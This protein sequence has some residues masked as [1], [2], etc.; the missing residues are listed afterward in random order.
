MTRRQLARNLHGLWERAQ[1]IH[2]QAAELLECIPAH[3]APGRLA[4]E[5]A[6]HDLLFFASRAAALARLAGAPPPQR[7]K[8]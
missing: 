2:L 6:L 8:P 4:L 1:T 7:R 5:L 3:E